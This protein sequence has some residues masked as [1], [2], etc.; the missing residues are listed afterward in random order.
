MW[1]RVL[2]IVRSVSRAEIL[3]PDRQSPPPPIVYG[4]WGLVRQPAGALEFGGTMPA[5]IVRLDRYAR[6]VI[7]SLAAGSADVRGLLHSSLFLAASAGKAAI[8][9]LGDSA[10]GIRSGVTGAVDCGYTA[11]ASGLEG[12]EKEEAL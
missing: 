6:G 4:A 11:S 10:Y 7:E 9:R 1:D 2:A 12:L 3:V 5:V 8:V